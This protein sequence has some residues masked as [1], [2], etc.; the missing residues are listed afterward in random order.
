MT[1]ADE[2]ELGTVLAMLDRH[3][4]V[5]VNVGHGR[6]V[7][8]TRR[9]WLFIDA[10]TAADGEVGEVVSWPSVAASWLRPACR[11]ASGAPDM[12]VVADLP[13]GWTGFGPRLAAAGSWRATRTVAFSGLAHPDLPRLAGRDASEGLSG[14]LPGSGT[15]R[16]ANGL[17]HVDRVPAS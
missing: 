2:L 9:A 10:W 11:F 1:G 14:A 17:L 7:T 8:S 13:G 4:P 6:D 12:W 15:W 3:R 16:F 5:L